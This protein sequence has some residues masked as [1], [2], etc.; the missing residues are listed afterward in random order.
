MYQSYSLE[1]DAGKISG[2]IYYYKMG[3]RKF[4]DTKK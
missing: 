3:S 4:S 2:R 1:F